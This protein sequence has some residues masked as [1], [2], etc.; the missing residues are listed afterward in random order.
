MGLFRSTESGRAALEVEAAPSPGEP[1]EDVRGALAAFLRVQAGTLETAVREQGVK[2][3]Q[4]EGLMGEAVRGFGEALQELDVLAKNQY[5]LAMELHRV[6]EVSLE[7]QTGTQSVEAFASSI[8]G[9]LD[10]FVQAMME[11]G[12]SSFQLVDEMES[13]QA[14][15][16]SMGESL[17]ELAEV[18]TRTHMLALNA[19]IEAAHAR[20]YGAGFS[21]VAGEVQKL[22]DRSGKISD[23]IS[24]QMRETGEALARA[25]AQAG[26]IASN[27][28]NEIIHSKQLAETMV[29]AISESEI[30]A[31][32][33]VARME[34]VGMAVTA[35][36]GR[37]IQALQ[38]EDMVRQILQGVAVGSGQLAALSAKLQALAHE[39]DLGGMPLAELMLQA[40]REFEA[41]GEAAHNSVQAA[42]MDSGDVE[43]F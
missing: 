1:L 38:F 12:K 16:A 30:R 39:V 37:S 21:V 25:Q 17:G 5:G 20:K 15:S 31:Q 11:I 19:S 26:L 22:A 35:Q 24:G 32:A 40:A 6:L 14:R 23:Q 13:I 18:A 43:L 34:E 41:F 10:L 3:Q 33:L 28:F 9:T 27:D 29:T 2:L 36:V 4:A 42:S 7:G 8:R